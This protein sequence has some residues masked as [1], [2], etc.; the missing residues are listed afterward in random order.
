MG[1]FFSNIHIRKSK[2]TDLKKVSSVITTILTARGYCLTTQ[3]EAQG[4]IALYTSDSSPWISLYSDL[5]ECS[6]PEA[7]A[8]E[9]TALSNATQSDVLC[10]SCMDSDYLFL[11]LIN[12]A[13]QT[14]AFAGVGSSA[15]LGIGRR[16]KTADWKEKVKD[17]ESF[18]KALKEK[19]VFAEDSLIQLADSLE[20]P[21]E[22]SL[23]DHEGLN[24]YGIAAHVEYLYFALSAEAQNSEPPRFMIRRYGLMPCRPGKPSCEF[25]NNMGGAS[26]GVAIIFAG[27]YVEQDEITFT[28]VQFEYFN[29]SGERQIVPLTLRKERLSNGK[30]CY[31]AD[32]PQFKIPEKVDDRLPPMKYSD[33]EHRRSFGVRFTPHGNPRKFL[34]I[35]FHIIPLANWDGQCCWC[36][37]YPAGSKE[38]FIQ[39]HNELWG[40]H[41]MT[42]QLLSPDDF[43]MD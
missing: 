5:I 39:Q 33:E 8:T 22:Q 3:E 10:I 17:F 35:R 43:D 15:G 21:K 36:V 9:A 19:Y 13:D 38:E 24:M 40:E 29:R 41:G 37:W 20:L 12:P 31:R 4:S 30:A 27:D 34:D 25:A 6:S 28:D 11:N 7:A 26:R 16:T 23:T 42:E 18:K 1:R 32:V 14:N 2:T